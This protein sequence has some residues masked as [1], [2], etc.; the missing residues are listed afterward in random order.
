MPSTAESPS[1][2]PLIGVTG[3]RRKASAIEGFPASLSDLDVDLYLADYTRDIVAAGGLPILIP[4][5]API[6]AYVERLD[7]IVLTGGADIEPSHY[8]AEPDGNGIYEPER[9]G[10]ELQLLQQALAS[11]VPLLGICRGLQVLNVGAGGSLHQN[12][13]VHARYDTDPAQAVHEVTFTEHSRLGLLYGEQTSVNSLH[14]QTID[15]L[16]DGLTVT[17]RADDGTIEALEMPGCDVIAVQWHP[18]MRP[19]VEPVFDWLI[20]QASRVQAAG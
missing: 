2:Q 15:Q 16:G 10:L 17:G 19:D 4:M 8:D 11:D 13:P 18:E 12:V 14:H 5:D 9:D 20:K 3:R 6:D 1:P 7:G